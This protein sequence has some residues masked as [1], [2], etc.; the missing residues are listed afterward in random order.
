M[1]QVVENGKITEENIYTKK[2]LQSDLEE[3]YTG[4]EIPSFLIYSQ[5]FTILWSVLAFSS[6]MPILYP[7]ALV[8][9]M[10]LFCVY[11]TLLLKY[12]CKTTAFNQELPDFSIFYFKIGIGIH[13][14]MAAF[15]F[16]NKNL[17]PANDGQL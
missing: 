8:S 2:Y 17:L 6:G 3:L 16:S 10:I 12:Y 13:I 9:F 4:E 5:L 11:K 1:I 14:I 15:I 7:V